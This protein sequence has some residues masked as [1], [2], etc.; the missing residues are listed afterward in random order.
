MRE[1]FEFV[2]Q[3]PKPVAESS[4]EEAETDTIFFKMTAGVLMEFQVLLKMELSG[5]RI[6]GSVLGAVI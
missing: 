1:S 4:M 6:Q 2:L 5:W 3:Q